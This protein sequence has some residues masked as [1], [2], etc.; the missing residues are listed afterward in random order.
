MFVVFSQRGFRIRRA[1][2]DM[3]SWTGS[4]WTVSAPLT[5]SPSATL[6]LSASHSIARQTREPRPPSE[7]RLLWTGRAD[8]RQ[9][10]LPAGLETDTP[11]GLGR[12]RVA[13]GSAP[14][15]APRTV[16]A[17]LPW[18]C[19]WEPPK[20]HVERWGQPRDL[21]G[22][23]DSFGEEP[24]PETWANRPHDCPGAGAAGTWSGAFL[25]LRMHDPQ[26]ALLT[27]VQPGLY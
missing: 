7:A 8:K 24:G 18:R 10:P 27:T 6:W 25:L 22:P 20:E 11:S 21:E 12:G 3:A 23:S 5:L 9:Q 19:E 17:P 26:S 2:C 4:R 14:S 13:V 16:Q 1:G 15:S